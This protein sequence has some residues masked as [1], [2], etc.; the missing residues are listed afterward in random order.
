[1]GRASAAFVAEAG[2]PRI[3]ERTL[4]A[5]ERTILRARAG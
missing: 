2:W 4:D 5:Y 1:M 3:A